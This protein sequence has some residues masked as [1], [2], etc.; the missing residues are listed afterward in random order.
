METTAAASWRRW[1]LEEA[2]AWLWYHVRGI[3]CYR[4]P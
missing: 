1:R 3:E 4:K 2:L